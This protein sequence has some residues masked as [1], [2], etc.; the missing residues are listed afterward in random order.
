MDMEAAEA[1][2]DVI[3][4]PYDHKEFSQTLAQLWPHLF[5]PGVYL[6]LQLRIEKALRE[7][8]AQRGVYVSA[9]KLRKFLARHCKH[10]SYLRALADGGPRHGVN[11]EA[12]K[13]ILAEHMASAGL[14][15]AKPK[16]NKN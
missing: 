16:K 5:A 8:A 6:P 10:R 14:R 4:S 7:D 13:L 2:S 11:G 15:L 1:G 9:N 3:Q 12:T